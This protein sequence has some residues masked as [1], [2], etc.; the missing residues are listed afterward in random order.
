[1]VYLYH[2]LTGEPQNDNF[3]DRNQRATNYFLEHMW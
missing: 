2:L 1:M 3:I